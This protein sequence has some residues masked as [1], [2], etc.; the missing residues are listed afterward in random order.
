MSQP[1]RSLAGPGAC[2]PARGCGPTLVTGGGMTAAAPAP[3]G[4]REGEWA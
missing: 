2:P 1:T 4:T 3:A